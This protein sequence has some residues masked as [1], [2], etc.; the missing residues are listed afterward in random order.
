MSRVS[1]GYRGGNGERGLDSAR[2]LVAL[3]RNHENLRSLVQS[4]KSWS[5]SL[6][7]ENGIREFSPLP[8]VVLLNQRAQ[9]RC[10]LNLPQGIYNQDYRYH[11]IPKK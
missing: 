3:T 11:V 7:L 5:S 8:S 6:E 9:A 2:C 4:A 10:R 1:G